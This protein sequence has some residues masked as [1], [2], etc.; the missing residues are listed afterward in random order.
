MMILKCE[1]HNT[2]ED[3]VC[4]PGLREHLRLN[5]RPSV[6]FDKKVWMCSCCYWVRSKQQ[7]P[8]AG[9]KDPRDK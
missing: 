7:G 5:P 9:L 8:R 6:P 3:L 1:C 2:S 4:G